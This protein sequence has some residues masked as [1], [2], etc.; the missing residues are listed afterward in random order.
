MSAPGRVF[1][2]S[3]ASAGGERAR[4]VFNP[5]ATFDLARDL[6]RPEGAAASRARASLSRGRR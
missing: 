1:L 3:P 4:L 2:L 6:R 5:D